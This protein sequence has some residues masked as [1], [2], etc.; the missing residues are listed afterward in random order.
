METVSTWTQRA[1][2][3]QLRYSYTVVSMMHTARVLVLVVAARHVDH[4]VVPRSRGVYLHM[5]SPEVYL[6]SRDEVSSTSTASTTTVVVESYVEYRG[7]QAQATQSGMSRETTH[8]HHT[9][10]QVM[11]EYPEWVIHLTR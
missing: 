2:V 1:G 7:A 8:S 9:S 5:T 6:M 3:A 10:R 4:P 11:C